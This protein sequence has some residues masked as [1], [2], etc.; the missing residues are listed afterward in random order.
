MSALSVTYSSI[1][2]AYLDAKW[3]IGIV[4]SIEQNI[5]CTAY[6]QLL[7]W[8]FYFFFQPPIVFRHH[9]FQLS[10]FTKCTPL[11]VDDDMR[12][13]AEVTFVLWYRSFVQFL[14]VAGIGACTQY[15]ANMAI[16]PG[17]TSSGQLSRGRVIYQCL[18][19]DNF[20][21][22]LGIQ[23]T[24]SLGNGMEWVWFVTTS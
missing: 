20:N 9:F 11:T 13:L 23:C 3:Y 18:Y 12:V 17:L 22:Q 10:S 15:Q 16:R 14:Q 6:S 5:H 1:L 8:I 24:S 19:F 4:N 7:S 2:F 21:L